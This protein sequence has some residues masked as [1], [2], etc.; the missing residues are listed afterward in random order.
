MKLLIIGD[1]AGL[2][3]F[4][5][6]KKGY[7]PENIVVWENDDRHI[8]AVRQI[9][10]RITVIKELDHLIENY[11]KHFDV[12]IGNPPFQ[13]GSNKDKAS[14]LWTR[15][16]A[17]VLYLAKDDGV[18]SL[19]TPTTWCSPS[20]DFKSK[21]E[22]YEGDVRLWD[23]F[24]RFTS[25]ADVDNVRAHFPGVG[26]TFGRVTVYKSGRD[27]LSFTGGY[28]T[29]LGFLPKSGDVKEIFSMID[30]EENLKKYF[31][32]DQEHRPGI[33]VSIPTTRNF[34]NN[35]DLIEIL[36]GDQIG[37]AGSVDPRN[38]YYIYTDTMEDAEIV[39][40]I[41]INAAELLCV[42][43]RWVGF[44]NL[45]MVEYLKYTPAS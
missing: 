24:N 45:K 15:F 37:T 13:D 35:L 17:K 41:I 20:N 30:K 19:I 9:N 14:R 4:A 6:I 3:S 5:A 31:K 8:Y 36:T 2:H 44:L 32:M 29:E 38:Y 7:L 27:G 11:M 21:S 18:V 34:S 12:I 40:G 43:C 39:K 23:T 42:H 25:I 33:K 10:N 28:S 26:S 1:P 22:G 16:W